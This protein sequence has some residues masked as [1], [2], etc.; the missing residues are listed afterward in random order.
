MAEEIKIDERL[1]TDTRTKTKRP[2]L[3]KVFLVNDDYTAMDFVVSILESVF[4]KSP[5][6]AV[7]IM[8]HVH[9]RGSG[10]A[11]VYTKDIAETKINIVHER[12]RKNSFPLKCIMEKE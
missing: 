12:A 10:L 6:E 7:Q 11:G 3:Y 1:E 2:E 5:V 8:L 4:R 9:K